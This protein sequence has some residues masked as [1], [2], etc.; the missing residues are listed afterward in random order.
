MLIQQCILDTRALTTHFNRCLHS[1]RNIC[2]D[3]EITTSSLVSVDEI[4]KKN[5][6]STS[7][8]SNSQ[9]KYKTN[10]LMNNEIQT[11]SS[12]SVEAISSSKKDLG[13]VFLCGKGNFIYGVT[14]SNHPWYYFEEIDSISSEH[15]SLPPK[16]LASISKMQDVRQ[17]AVN[18]NA[19]QSRK[20][21]EN[22]KFM[23]KN[24]PLNTREASFF[25]SVLQFKYNYEMYSRS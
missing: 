16:M 11:C 1:G 15:D 18:L 25:F 20:Y 8:T 2:I 12:T 7:Y 17:I 4:K 19:T 10:Q 5:P 6:P 21:F 24:K 13:F 3:D 9:G 22:G 23:F 14:V